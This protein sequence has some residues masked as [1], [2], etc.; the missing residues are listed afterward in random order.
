MKK[1]LDKLP[2]K[3]VEGCDIGQGRIYNILVQIWIK[4][5]IQEDIFFTF[6]NIARYNDFQHFPLFG[7]DFKYIYHLVH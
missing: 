2:Q 7:M 3:L 5:R 6:F 1:L 4:W